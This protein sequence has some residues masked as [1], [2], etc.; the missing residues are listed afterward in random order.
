VDSPTSP[1]APFY[2]P[3]GVDGGRP[4]FVPPAHVVAA[5]SPA[6]GRGNTT[7]TRSTHVASGAIVI[8]N[9][10]DPEA[11]GRVVRRELATINGAQN[12]ADHAVEDGDD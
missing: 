4:F 1:Q 2:R 7:I 12:D 6:A 8:H 10:T 9:A 3:G 5:T 11:V